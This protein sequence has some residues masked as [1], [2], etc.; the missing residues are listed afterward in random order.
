M[1]FLMLIHE[2]DSHKP[3]KYQ[4]DE[5]TPAFGFLFS[6]PRTYFMT[7]QVSQLKSF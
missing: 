4:H 7:S 5:S 6:F 3:N 2:N 1:T